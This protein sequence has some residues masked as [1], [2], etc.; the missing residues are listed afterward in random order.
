[1]SSRRFNV[2]SH[3]AK[4]PWFS[5]TW[6]EE[7]FYSEYAGRL[8]LQSLGNDTVEEYWNLRKSAGLFDVPERPVEIRGRDAVRFLNRA[9][10]RPVDKLRVGRGSYGLLCHRDGGMVC[11]GIL[12]RLADDR[13]WYVHAD[14][15]VYLWL[16]A[17][18]VDYEV[19]IHDPGSWVL[20]IQGPKS[21]EVLAQACDG[22]APDEFRYFDAFEGSMGGQPVLVS[23]TGWTAELGF[24]V[25]NMDAA[26]DGPALWDHLI[27]AG[28]EF[29]M[30][31]GSQMAMNIRRIEAGILNYATDMDWD[32]TPYDMGLEAFVD[33]DGHDFVGRD[34]LRDATKATRFSGF[35][36]ESRKIPYGAALMS[37]GQAIGRVTAYEVSP[38]LEC[39]IGF[40]LFESASG[41]DC[42]AIGVNDRAGEP[43]PVE[44]VDLPFY[45]AE[46]NIPRGL[47]SPDDIAQ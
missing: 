11:D 39:G 13:F 4:S 2:V 6:S 26:V 44:L 32:T 9:F 35:K 28:A 10:T 16:S 46:K 30:R 29:G 23:R 19:E 18:A 7:A 5:R 34:A 38:Y 40:A 41:L 47:P 15:N 31:G 14:A 42:S 27:A 33:L 45:D 37:S 20:Q 36:C 43:C 24:E 1:M 17:L 8:V 12:F 22:G 3:C 21:L 25:Y